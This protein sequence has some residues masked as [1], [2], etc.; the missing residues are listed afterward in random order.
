MRQTISILAIILTTVFASCENDKNKQLQKTNSTEQTNSMVKLYKLIDNKLHYWE[1]WDK[2]DKTAFIHWGIVGQRGQNKEVKSGLFSN[3]R[4][5][6]QKEIDEK[7]KEGYKERDDNEV[8]FLEI[9]YI[10]D[11]FGTEQDLDKRHRL[12]EK[13]DEVLGWT[14]LGN[15][16]GGS[17][18]SGTM[19]VGCVVVDFEIAK[20]VIADNLKDTEFANYS[21]IFKMDSE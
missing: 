8:S 11:G 21:R 6:V 3:F 15:C 16:D 14:G 17:I 13:M 10:I 9:E 4:K 1:T 20:K 5:S 2:D 7:I 18:G 19:E 12:E